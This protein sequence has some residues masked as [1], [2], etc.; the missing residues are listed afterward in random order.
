MVSFRLLGV[1]TII[2]I[3]GLLTVSFFVLFAIR[4]TDL[5]SLKIFGYIIAVLLWI[6]AVL[7]LAAGIYTVSTG[8][9]P[10]MPMME[11]MLRYRM[12]G[13]FM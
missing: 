7:V 12:R 4:K 6:S 2:P 9:H 1:F 13:P 8:R 10:M 3:T 11:Q 5:K